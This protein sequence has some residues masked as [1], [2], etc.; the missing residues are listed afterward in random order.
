M[1]INFLDIATKVRY[2]I[3]KDSKAGT[4][5]TSLSTLE[6]EI[7]NLEEGLNAMSRYFY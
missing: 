4:I 2:K 3:E 7:K 6:I 5:I 1:V